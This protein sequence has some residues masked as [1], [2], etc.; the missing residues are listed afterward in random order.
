[1]PSFLQGSWALWME[2]LFAAQRQISRR[3]DPGTQYKARR[4]LYVLTALDEDLASAAVDELS[5]DT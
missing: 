3:A 4:R 5:A 1:M 2:P